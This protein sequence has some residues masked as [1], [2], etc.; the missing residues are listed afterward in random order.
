MITYTTRRTRNSTP[1]QSSDPAHTQSTQN[2][3][4]FACANQ[5]K[6]I[7]HKLYLPHYTV[8]RRRPTRTKPFNIGLTTTRVHTHHTHDINAC[9]SVIC[10]P[11]SE[12]DIFR[13]SRHISR[14]S[15]ACT[16][17]YQI[18]FASS[19]TSICMHMCSCVPVPQCMKH[20]SIVHVESW[21]KRTPRNAPPLRNITHIRRAHAHNNAV[22]H[23]E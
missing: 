3:L 11:P 5:P 6:S 18:L 1:S 14:P 8:S 10:A 21:S 22:R 20:A 16:A 15:K 13:K 2:Y 12:G 23:T 7:I 9:I 4:H 17:I 19:P